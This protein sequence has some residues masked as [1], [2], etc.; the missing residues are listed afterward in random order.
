MPYDLAAATAQT[1]EIFVAGGWPE[2]HILAHV[3]NG[4]GLA[5]AAVLDCLAAGADGIWCS[6]SR[7]GAATGHANSLTTIANLHRL[8]NADVAARFSLPGLRSAAVEIT[9][10]TTG[11]LPHP[12]TELYGARALDICFD[13]SMMGGDATALATVF[14]VAPRTR[15]TS[16]AT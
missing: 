10:I 12:M 1:R 16:M 7:E 4:F 8:G 6:I 11:Q 15:I 5:E 13:P 14:G 3:H 2:G 9:R